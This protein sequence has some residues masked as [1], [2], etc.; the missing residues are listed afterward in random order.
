MHAIASSVSVYVAAVL[1]PKVLAFCCVWNANRN[2]QRSTSATSAAAS[3]SSS[4]AASSS[5]GDDLDDDSYYDRTKVVKSKAEARA[6]RFGKQ[7]VK[8]AQLSKQSTIIIR[9]CSIISSTV[10]IAITITFT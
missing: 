10:Q 5:A 3:Q 1:T 2:K 4:T 7:P 6:S 9:N 8:S